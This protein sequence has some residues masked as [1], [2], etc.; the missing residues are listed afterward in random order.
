MFFV[1]KDL[2]LHGQEHT[3]TIHEVDDGQMVLH[4]DLLQPQVFLSRDREPCTRLYGLVVSDD[5]ALSSAH[6]AHT[7]NGAAGWTTTIFFIHAF[8]GERTDFNKGFVFIAQVFNPLPCSEFIFLV[9]FFDGFLSTA[10]AHF[11]PSLPQL[12]DGEFHFIFVLVE[13]HVHV[14][15]SC[16]ATSY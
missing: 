9:L 3:G 1:R 16:F 5:H 8:A 11:F 2:V 10:Q 13:F 6:I 7:C 12:A 14:H 4:R 15:H